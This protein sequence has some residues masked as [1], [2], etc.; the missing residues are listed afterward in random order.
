MENAPV[1]GHKKLIIVSTITLLSLICGSQAVFAESNISV[2]LST[3]Q[4]DLGLMA[5][6][7]N[8]ATQT[9]N[10][11]TTSPVGYTVNFATSSA[12]TSLVNKN[13]N[14]KAIPT[15]TLPSG[16]D[17]VPASSI[18]RGYG[19]S[20][21]GGTNYFPATNNSNPA[22]IFE[23][24]TA[25]TNSHTLTYGAK[26]ANTDIAGAYDNT[27]VI[28]AIAK[29]E[30]CPAN[31]ICYYGNGDDGTGTMDNQPATSNTNIYLIPSNFSRPGYGFAGWNTEPDGS[32]TN[33]GPNQIITTGDLSSLGFQL[34]A[35]WIQSSGSIQ[36]WQGCNTMNKGDIT[37]LTDNRD[38]NTYAVAKYEDGHC[39]MME[40]LRL[41]FSD[42]DLEINSL[43]TNNPKASFATYINSNHPPSRNDF[44]ESS[45]PSQACV[46]Q[47]LYNTN[48]TN[49]KLTASYDSN[50]DGSSWYSYGH[51]YNWYTATAGYGDYSFATAGNAVDGDICPAGWKLP[52]GYGV[53][54]D[55]ATLGVAYGGSTSS[56]QYTTR[57]LAYPLNYI[58]SGEQRGNSGYNRNASGGYATA[59][60]SSSTRHNNLWVKPSTIYV[61]DNSNLKS[62]G[63]TVRCI[64]NHRN[65]IT[66]NIH[67]D[68]NGGSGV[69]ADTTN[70]NFSTAVAA[71]NEF[72]KTNFAF[73]YWNTAADGSG[74]SVLAGNSVA[75]AATSMDIADGGTLT[76]YA[77]W[78]PVYTLAYD[79][80]GAN[81]GTMSSIVHQD[82][83]ASATQLRLMAPNFLRPGYGFA[84]WSTDS[85][86]A[87]KI[88]NSQQATIYGPSETITLTNS[89]LSK[90]DA[91]N[92]IT[93][94][95]VWLPANS[96]T[97]QN[98]DSTDCSALSV[99]D[100]L[101]LTDSRDNNTYA[102]AK[103]KDQHCWM[104]E[105]LRLNPH[106]V[107]F[108]STNTNSPTTA[109]I[110]NA[111]SID[112]SNTLCGDDTD[113]C[114]S[115]IAFNTNNINSTLTASP[116]SNN[117]SSYWYSYGVMYNWYTA[118]AGNGDF[119]ATSGSVSGD[120]C[121]AGWRLPTGGSG[122]EFSGLHSALAP[123]PSSV[124][125]QYVRAYPNNI[126]YSG[127]YNKT[128]PSGRS[129]QGRFWS[130]TADGSTKAYRFG[131]NV[132]ANITP[133]RSF[134]KWDAFAVRCIVKQFLI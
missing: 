62:R 27:F 44:C 12:T 53:D 11:S 20:I 108:S 121:P 65:S 122:G 58:L 51:Y 10:V 13:D 103:L 14:T 31:K 56:L 45:S 47:V 101:A 42:E 48:N 71:N 97:L 29:L 50:N 22:Q 67:Y 115:Q 77:I 25:G 96:N 24:F 98:F 93:L 102:V 43:N 21:D 94:Y 125:D 92:R 16:S 99:G 80:N 91:S 73:N 49:R 127:D 81:S 26:V 129:A 54:S 78:R 76:L 134:N 18:S 112:T 9:I 89:V 63:Q 23:T 117:T 1:R 100:I 90:A 40:N 3:N 57:W 37:A 46:D 19:Y 124:L 69:M 107:T 114:I 132:G 110:N 109:F 128:S 84:G 60:T 32:G 34:Y 88:A 118:T 119:T 111:S 83:N 113:A 95:A 36:N 55:M 68:S 61:Y 2:S 59:N 74:T 104:V 6:N 105:N 33:Y 15:I 75:N 123:T 66:G 4:V 70:V 120:I 28:Y 82:I 133:A 85:N 52:T 41:D 38:N 17:S 106:A 72:T 39:W 8:S 86:A 131:V 7:F 116:D 126:I 5:D 30:P 79:G 35:R 130:A 87:A 64:Q